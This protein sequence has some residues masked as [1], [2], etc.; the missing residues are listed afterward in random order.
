VER[1]ADKFLSRED[2][3]RAKA[4]IELKAAH[5]AL[6]EAKNEEIKRLDT[7]LRNEIKRMVRAV[8]E[9]SSRLGD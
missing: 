3:V 5:Q 1:A 4:E 8:E 6:I 9:L 7:S 2:A